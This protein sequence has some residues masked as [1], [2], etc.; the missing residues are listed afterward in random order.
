MKQ[1]L[2]IIFF[3][4]FIYC[5]VNIVK[6]SFQWIIMMFMIIYGYILLM[7]KY[8]FLPWINYIIDGII[9]LISGIIFFIIIYKSLIYIIFLMG[10]S[11]L[12]YG[13]YRENP[14]FINKIFAIG[15][16]Y[17]TKK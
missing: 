17:L 5:I 6:K 8:S 11:I 10:L 7:S 4:I 12:S 16:S 3:S 2:N 1:Y 13:T 9:I 14:P 15:Y